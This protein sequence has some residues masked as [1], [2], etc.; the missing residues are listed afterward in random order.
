MKRTFPEGFLW[1]SATAAY[2]VEGAAREDGKGASIWDTYCHMPGR[3]YHGETGDV[4]CD[5]YHR[6]KED[7]ALMKA[8]GMKA[9]RFSISWPRILAAGTGK[10]NPKGIA[11]YRALAGE[12][13]DAGIEPL[14]TLYHWDLPQPLQDAGGWPARKT[15]DHFAD[16]AQVCFDEMGDLIKLWLTHNEPRNSAYFSHA[17][18]RAAPGGC[19]PE[20]GLRANHTILISHGLAVER[21]RECKHNDGQIGITLDPCPMRPASDKPEDVEATRRR[22]LWLN[23]IWLDPVLAGRNP[24]PFAP[25]LERCEKPCL[26][27]E[28]LAVVATPI[29]FLGLNYYSIET[30]AFDPYEM[31]TATKTM[32]KPDAK[33][34]GFLR[35][36]L[37]PQGLS[38]LFE[39]VYADYGKIPIYVT[40]NGLPTEG[41]VPGDDG[42]VA[43]DDRIDYTRTHLAELH[44]AIENG[45]DVRGYFHWS[46]L[47]NLEWKYGYLPLLGLVRVDRRTMERTVKKSGQWYQR[48]IAANGIED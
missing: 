21:F 27:D 17:M 23:R 42:V 19:C 12:L 3:T 29:D 15:A 32:P 44:K 46:L 39:A 31:L 1:G 24:E 33:V 6:Y 35:F 10:I 14:A 9:Y 16:Y 7:V 11:F 30:V 36:E 37:Y 8:L 38:E 5:H 25:W 48:V 22:D 45:I 13:R 20:D 4:A 41:E 34:V 18:D 47:D 28:E 40:E 2:Q 26:T 43:D